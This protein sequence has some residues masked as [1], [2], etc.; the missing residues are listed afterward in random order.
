MELFK[1]G[2]LTITLIDVLDVLVVAFVFYRLFM[3]LKGT[4]A[5]HMVIGLLV[6][7]LFTILSQ[8]LN[9]R[10]LNWLIS[11]LRTVWVVAFVILFQPELRR[12]L[13]YLGQ[14]RFVKIF[15]REQSKEMI[16]VVIEA[17][18]ELS[19][20]N[21]GA[22]MVLQRDVG[23]G[24]ILET[25][26]ILKSELSSALLTTIFTPRTS[27]HDGAV[28]INGDSI[29]AA[30]CTL[31]LSQNQDAGELGMRH[32]AALG[33]SEET[34]SVCVIVSEE[35]GNISIAIAGVLEENFNKEQL[36]ARLVKLFSGGK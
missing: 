3:L 17:S 26:I 24:M 7:V 29:E 30:A 33:V 18:V 22:L 2:F 9:M 8:M 16:D 36:H 11:N 19:K 14:S 10:A 13:V 35:T 20:R 6:I 25:G 15:W 12:L 27:L 1:L 32:K 5:I 28:L 23:L 34:D 31:P 4:R 21:F